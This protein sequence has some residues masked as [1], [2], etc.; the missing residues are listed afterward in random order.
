M[1]ILLVKDAGHGETPSCLEAKFKR[2]D[3]VKVRNKKALAHFPREAVIGAVA[4][5]GFPADW[6]LADLMN[7]ARPLMTMIPRRTIGYI[8]VN[9]GD[10]TPY[11]ARES[12]LLPSGKP[13]VQI[14]GFARAPTVSP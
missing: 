1:G 3:V 2:G 4:P 14:G 12:D 5:P 10:R 8:L 6:A 13:A 9:E 7:E 11:L